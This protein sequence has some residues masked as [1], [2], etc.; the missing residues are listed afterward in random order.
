VAIATVTKVGLAVEAVKPT[1]P[2]EGLCFNIDEE[3]AR[4]YALPFHIES[5]GSG[6][7]IVTKEEQEEQTRIRKARLAYGR[8]SPKHRGEYREPI[9]LCGDV[10]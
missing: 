6:W 3:Q 4:L 8:F 10:F 9:P 7:C 2:T 1:K 5:T